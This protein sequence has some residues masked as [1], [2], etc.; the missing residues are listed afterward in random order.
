MAH[1][2]SLYPARMLLV[3]ATIVAWPRVAAGATYI[4]NSTIDAVDAV[5]GNGVCATA[6]GVCTLRAAVQEGNFHAG[7]HV[8]TLPAGIYALTIPPGSGAL[9][10]TG[11]LN[12]RE[13]VTINGATAATTIIDG[14]GLDRVFWVDAGGLTLNDVTVQNGNPA[15]GPGGCIAIFGLN[16]TLARVVVKSCR[17]GSAGGGIFVS[18]PSTVTLTDTTISQNVGTGGN[19]GGGIYLAYSVTAALTRVTISGNSADVA[20]GIRVLGSA[21]FPSTVTLTDSVVTQNVVTSSA[22][23]GGG[24][25]LE[26]AVTGTLNHVTVSDNSGNFGAGIFVFGI[27]ALTVADSAI[28]QNTNPTGSGGGIYAQ[29]SPVTIR[30]TTISGNSANRGGGIAQAGDK[31]TLSNTTISGNTATD[32]GGAVYRTPNIIGSELTLINATIASN[33]SAV[34]AAVDSNDAISVKN[35]IIANSTGAAPTNCSTE[36]LMN[37]LGNNLE[38]PGTSCGFALASDRRADPLLDTLANNGGL[39][40]TMALIPGSPAIDTG[41]DAACA[42]TP[43]SGQDQ[44]GVS[45]STGAGAHCDMGAYERVPLVFTDN[46]IVAGMTIR[47]LHILE[48]RSRI[49]AVR[50]ARG[51][52]PFTWTDPTLTLGS[53]IIKAQHIIDLRSALAEAYVAATLTPPTYTDALLTTGITVARAVHIAELRAAVTAIE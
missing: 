2:P 16:L 33:S 53:A 32:S 11:D 20:A 15:G 31:L 35:S 26:G 21:D 42:A 6:G 5:P 27:S 24:V 17:T 41:D 37:D 48:L 13:G 49:D 25:S 38:F 34:A 1:H 9:S 51:L 43:V 39:T 14:N 36:I 50:V 47:A 7:P 52:P 4:V 18:G 23:S 29:T 40:R 22:A 12:I 45:R 8:I 19:G 10:A 30:R 3:A 44:R 28:V 46:P